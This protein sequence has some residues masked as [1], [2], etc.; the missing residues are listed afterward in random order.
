[1]GWVVTLRV[2][3]PPNP[4]FFLPLVKKLSCK[5]LIAYCNTCFG[6]ATVLKAFWDWLWPKEPTRTQGVVVPVQQDWVSRA[7]YDAAIQKLEQR[8]DWELSE[9]YDKFSTLHA[10][11]AKRSQRQDGGNSGVATV[12]SEP[13]DGP[14]SILHDRRKPWSV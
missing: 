13:A 10:R 11:A 6:S 8:V 1:M 4:P 7:E 3:P 5:Y 9:W 2:S 12:T 14:A